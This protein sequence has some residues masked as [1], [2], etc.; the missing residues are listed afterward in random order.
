VAEVSVSSLSPAFHERS[1]LVTTALVLAGV[2]GSI[3]WRF[4]WASAL[5]AYLYL[6]AALSVASVLDARTLRVPNLLVLPSYP[7]GVALLAVA[8]L[9][10]DDW[11]SLARAA[12]A[13]VAVGALYL[14]LA[15]AA[16]GSRFGLADVELGGL[17]GLGLGWLSWSAVSSGIIVGWL[18]ALVMVIVWRGGHPSAS[19]RVWPCGPALC[20]GAL[21]A[22]LA[23]R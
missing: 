15:L 4:G 10:D 11:W 9:A 6:G 13:M 12:I 22:L 23:V 16:G 19:H 20:L 7:I 1:S 17:L 5:P 18:I 14:T 21:V 8:S 3:I 2:V